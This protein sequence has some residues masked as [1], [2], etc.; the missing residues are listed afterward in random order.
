MPIQIR[1]LRPISPGMD[2]PAARVVRLAPLALLALLLTALLP[3]AAAHAAARPGE[4]ASIVGGTP[5][6]DGTFAPLAFVTSQV[7][8]TTAMACTG[9]VIAPAVVLTAAHC[10]VD[11][12]TGA[13]RSAAGVT[14]LTGRV[15]RSASGGQVLGASRVLVHPAYDRAAIR[16][17]L[18][19]ILL[20]EATT[21][22]P[23]AVVGSGD[24]GL[25]SGGTPAA[26]AGWGLTTPGDAGAA[27]RLQTAAT[28]ILDPSACTR[29]LGAD[30]DNGATIC[31]VDSPTFAAATCRG[32]SGGPLIVVRRD[33]VPVQAGVISWGSEACTARVPQAYTR[34]STYADWIAAQVAAAPTPP[35]G[36]GG[37]SSSGGQSGGSGSTASGSRG[38]G[39][40]AAPAAPA[41][42]WYRGRTAQRRAIAVRVGARGGAVA[43]VRVALAAR[44]VPGRRARSARTARRSVRTAS[45]VL[46]AGAGRLTGGRRFAASR[47]TGRGVR[48]HVAGRFDAV[49]AL[50]GTVRASWRGSGARCETGTVAFTA[51]R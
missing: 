43:T 1:H 28:T 27:Q 29:L 15:D 38:G 39:A 37:G 20:S 51:R 44:C 6:D 8:Q 21:A 18:A 22:P 36:L 10:L 42:G 13:P 12:Q 26:I 48:L 3:A 41:T 46:P 23:L 33:G 45:V 2:R 34:L 25:A 31:A 24:A 47:T 35:R 11:E 14:V 30:F 19:L 4:P 49:G 17:D 9:T 7:S 50:T 32:D 16:A 5:A 40:A